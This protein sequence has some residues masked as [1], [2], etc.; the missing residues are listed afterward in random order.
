MFYVLKS[1]V[2]LERPVGRVTKNTTSPFKLSTI[3]FHNP[4]MRVAVI[5]GSSSGIGQ[6][7]AMAFAEQGYAVL[8]H[9][10]RNLSGLCETV[11][12]VEQC[13]HYSPGVERLRCVVADVA[14]LRARQTLVQ[15][16]FAWRGR[17]DVWV[18]NAGADIL[19]TEARDWTFEQKLKLLW[20]VDV[21]GTAS[22]SRLVGARM[23]EQHGKPATIINVGWDQAFQGM[24]GDSGQLFCTAKSAV[25]GFTMSL[26]QSLAPRVRVNCVAPGWIQTAWGNVAAGY[27]D[28]RARRESLLE[29]WGSPT[30]VAC[31]IRWLASDDATFING[32]I[33]PVN[34][35]RR[36][37]EANPN[38]WA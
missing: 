14:D 5:T 29:R 35:G 38:P 34:G 7:T 6:A 9:A 4:I 36:Y 18:N 19:T 16:A 24:E 25:M 1:F 37:G 13:D 12:F 32:Q 20:D 28:V 26:A 8:L 27:W 22:L 17:V 21:C 3:A 31:A 23:L 30:D 10:R 33:I 2:G 11:R 15:A